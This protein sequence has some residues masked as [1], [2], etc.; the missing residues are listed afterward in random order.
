MELKYSWED[1]PTSVA[2]LEPVINTEESLTLR[3]PL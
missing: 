1:A 2:E 3:G